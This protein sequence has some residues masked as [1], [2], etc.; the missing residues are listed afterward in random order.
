MDAVVYNNKV[1]QCLFDNIDGEYYFSPF[2]YEITSDIDPLRNRILFD[3][4]SFMFA[5]EAEKAVKGI[6]TDFDLT[7]IK[8]AEAYLREAIKGSE[9]LR[10][11]A[12]KQQAI[13]SIDSFLADSYHN[14]GVVLKIQ[15][16]SDDAK[17]MFKISEEYEQPYFN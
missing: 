13:E 2:F 12:L 9:K 7:V 11:Y 5:Y 6:K 1:V 16:K 14:L 17:M 15:G 4:V 3:M 8:S 10:D